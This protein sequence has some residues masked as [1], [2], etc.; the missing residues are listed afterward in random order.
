MYGKPA[1]EVTLV[2]VSSGGGGGVGDAAAKTYK[3]TWPYLQIDIQL[4]SW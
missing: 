4:A 2:V 3:R 1:K